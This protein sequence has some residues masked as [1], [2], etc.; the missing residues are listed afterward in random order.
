MSTIPLLGLLTT[1]TCLSGEVGPRILSKRLGGQFLSP[2]GTVPSFGDT[3]RYDDGTL[4]FGLW[5]PGEDVYWAMRFTP[6]MDCTLKEAH[7]AI[8]LWSGQ[9]PTCTLIVWD[10]NSG[11]PGTR[12]FDTTFIPLTSLNIIDITSSITYA[13][14]TDFW[15]GYFLQ[16]PAGMDTT[17]AGADSGVDY[18]ERS[19]IGVSGVWYTMNDL[20]GDGDL[21]IRAFVEYYGHDVGTDSITEPP[22][23]VL[24]ESTYTPVAWVHNYGIHSEVFQVECL[25]S[26]GGY[27]D[28]F[29]V[30]SLAP[31]ADTQ[32]VFGQWTVPPDDSTSYT[33]CVASLLGTDTELSND[34]L[35]KGVYAV[36][37]AAHDL[38]VD[39][40]TS[41]PDTIMPESA[42]SPVGW[43]HNYGDHGETS[44]VV[45]EIDSYGYVVYTDTQD[46]IDLAPGGDEEVMFMPWT[47]PP[48]QGVTYR[49]CVW[50][51]LPG[52][53]DPSNDTLC[54]VSYAITGVAEEL[55]VHRPTRASLYQNIPNPFS[56]STTLFYGVPLLG[57]V[58]ISIYDACGRLVRTLVDAEATPGNQRTNWDGRDDTGLEVPDG[59][60]FCK[61]SM[62][63]LESTVKLVLIR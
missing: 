35:C 26:P 6:A 45:C 5:L 59:V 46:V 60:Y 20:G 49:T 55:Y 3:I 12:V 8:D 30:Q 18:N 40:I 31:G 24:P 16:A 39:S 7:C 29:Q 1:A 47:V 33:M 27:S 25:I 38:G 57:R 9:P 36:V 23:T 43:V 37:P 61:L 56:K 10:D 11:E 53:S 4:T 17:L 41:P 34:T 19:G 62:G 58:N 32:C 15:I 44:L 13:E 21:V 22:D 14:S 28:T 63:R 42:Y 54:Q 52:D 51:L 50:T 48:E 2:A